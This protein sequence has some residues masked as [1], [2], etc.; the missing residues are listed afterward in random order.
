MIEQ[1]PKEQSLLKGLLAIEPKKPVV[2]LAMETLKTQE[3]VD[4]FF[5]QYVDWLAE[6]PGDED[7]QYITEKT[8]Q[9]LAYVVQDYN[10]TEITERWGRLLEKVHPEPQTDIS[11]KKL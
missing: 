6:D 2:F 7:R 8:A 9:Y 4:L 11:P 10:D 3:E 1:G 5:T